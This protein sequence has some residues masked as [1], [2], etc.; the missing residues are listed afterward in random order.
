MCE[1]INFDELYNEFIDC[2]TQAG[3]SIGKIAWEEAKFVEGTDGNEM[4]YIHRVDILWWH[5]AHLQVAEQFVHNRF[6][7]LPKIT[8]VV[9]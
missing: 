4:A 3:I 7:D 9:F 1:S 5:L 2:Q 8:E 6:K